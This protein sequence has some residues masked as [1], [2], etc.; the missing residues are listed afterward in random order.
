MRRLSALAALGTNAR[1]VGGYT[2]IVGS[3]R[4][5]GAAARC[6]GVGGASAAVVVSLVS[7]CRERYRPRSRR[8]TTWSMPSAASPAPVDH[9]GSRR[10]TRCTRPGGR[11]R[12]ATRTH[13]A[14]ESTCACPNATHGAWLVFCLALVLSLAGSMSLGSDAKT[15]AEVLC[16]LTMTRPGVAVQQVIRLVTCWREA[17]SRWPSFD[18]E[19]RTRQR[20]VRTAP[21]GLLCLLQASR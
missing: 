10:L 5:L 15:A 6:L 14:G 19:R 16:R 4:P 2:E 21:F 8:K 18:P 7:A 11:D 1:G 13:R 20:F 12:C 17:L 9:L 3:A